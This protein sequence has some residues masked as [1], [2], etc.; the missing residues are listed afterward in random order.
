[1]IQMSILM[2][3]AAILYSRVHFAL[4]IHPCSR[5][6]RGWRSSRVRWPTWRPSARTSG[7]AATRTTSSPSSAPD[8]LFDFHTTCISQ[9]HTRSE[10]AFYP[11]QAHSG[12]ASTERLRSQRPQPQRPPLPPPHSHA[13]PLHC[14]LRDY[15]QLVETRFIYSTIWAPRRLLALASLV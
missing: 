12:A 4:L 9:P 5:S 7:P 1:M 13:L 11:K 10:S 2:L 15:I 8:R 3:W 14:T 6:S